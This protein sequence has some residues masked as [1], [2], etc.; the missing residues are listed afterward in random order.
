MKY[1]SLLLTSFGFLTTSS[2][3]AQTPHQIENDLLKSFKRIDYWEDYR[4]SNKENVDKSERG[5][6]SLNKA[7]DTFAEK[8]KFYTSN[9]P[10]TIN[11]EFSS[12]AQK[13]NNVTK[14]RVNI[15]TSTDGLFRIYSW[16][17]RSD[18]TMYSFSD[19]IQYKIGE[20]TKSSLIS[21]SD[22]GQ[23]KY[24][25]YYSDLYTLNAN[26]KTY[27]L[28]IY[29]GA[30][31]HVEAGQGIQIFAIENGKLNDDIKLIKTGS[32]LHSQLYYEY[33]FDGGKN[34][35]IKY[36]P[37]QKTIS[38][39]VVVSKGRVTNK[40]ITYKFTGQYFERVKN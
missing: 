25:Y 36:D 6:D 14:N 21:E 18:G 27:Y 7:C 24:V 10:F 13:R 4:N 23:W 17:T 28:A 8:L 29:N 3:F 33:L 11:Q 1:L 22:S 39:P 35:D 26:N 2:L 19:V 38:L 20:K 40:R 12:I 30:Y 32:G 34:D 16:D 9:Y 15:L 31:T 5:N 37:V